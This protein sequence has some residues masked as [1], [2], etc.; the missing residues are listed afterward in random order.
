MRYPI[1]NA[2]SSHVTRATEPLALCRETRD[3]VHIAGT[4]DLRAMWS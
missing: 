2:Q 4:I 3:V 1:T